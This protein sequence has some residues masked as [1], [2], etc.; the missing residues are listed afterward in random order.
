MA[1]FRRFGLFALTNIAVIFTIG[2]ILRLTGLD[3]YLA[4]SGVPYATT[5]LFAAIWGMGGAFISLLLS[6]FMVKASMGVQIVDPRNASGWQR[7]L[8]TRVQR[9]A[10]AAG[11][12][13]PEVGYYESPEINAFATG[14]SRNSALVAVSTGL[15]NGMDSEE[16]DGVLGHELSHVAN[17]DMVTMTLVQ[18]VINSFVIFFSW[19]V[20][21]VI[22]SQLNRN[23]DRGS[24]GGFFMEFMIRQL[25]MVV[26]G[27]LGSIVVAYVSRAREFRADAGG[28][29]LAGRSSMI[30]ALERLKVAF[31]RDPID[32]R[33]ETI[34]A[35]KISNRAGGLASLFATHPPL[36][37]RIAALRAKAY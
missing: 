3:V 9:L 29:K 24:S 20:S 4:K 7:D 37:E 12:P 35:L 10:S 30:A 6:K 26:F 27:L 17:G 28:A 13:M 21:K 5:L 1:L 34:A 2:L 8:L 36:E 19:I 25:L 31:T 23:D 11:L 18:G 33:G 15:L 22:V 16:L 14:P 32:Q